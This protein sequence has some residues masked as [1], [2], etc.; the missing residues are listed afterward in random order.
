MTKMKS[1]RLLGGVAIA[2]HSAGIFA[3]AALIIRMIIAI[4]FVKSV[5]EEAYYSSS[6]GD[7][8]TFPIL[9]LMG[10]FMCG[11]YTRLCASVNLSAGKKLFAFVIMSLFFAVIFAAFDIFIVKVYYAEL[12]KYNYGPEMFL[13]EQCRPF[14]SVVEMIFETV[15][16]YLSLIIFGYITR[17]ILSVKPVRIIVWAVGFALFYFTLSD[18]ESPLVLLAIPIMIGLIIVS[19]LTLSPFCAGFFIM[20]FM[21]S[22]SQPFS[23]IAVTVM[24]AV[25]YAECLLYL[26]R[27]PMKIPA[28][29]RRN[30]L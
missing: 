10:C 13:E 7:G 17:Y 26:R 6:F 1:K 8:Y 4:V 20:L 12:Y 28:E 5:G 30:L 29:K 2:F 19:I 21:R 3:A 22:D 15:T 16:A 25:L 27:Y 18:I 11:R 9:L 23:V 14:G 24:L